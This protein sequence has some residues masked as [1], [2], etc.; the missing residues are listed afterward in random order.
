[1]HACMATKYK[2]QCITLFLRGLSTYISQ[3]RH[4]FCYIRSQA[5]RGTCIIEL[6]LFIFLFSILRTAQRPEAYFYIWGLPLLV[7]LLNTY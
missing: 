7:S 2:V 6:K 1:M 4:T 5:Y 3:L